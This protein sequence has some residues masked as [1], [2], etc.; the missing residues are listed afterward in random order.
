MVKTIQAFAMWMILLPLVGVSQNSWMPDVGLRV[1]TNRSSINL[2]DVN[3]SN[4]NLEPRTS[5]GLAAVLSWKITERTE[6]SLEPGFLK[7]GSRSAIA[8]TVWPQRQDTALD[9]TLNYF[10]IP[11][12]IRHQRYESRRVNPFIEAGLHLDH[13]RN[14]SIEN[15]QAPLLDEALANANPNKLAFSAG[16]GYKNL[17]VLDQDISLGLRVFRDLTRT[18]FDEERKFIKQR[19]VQLYVRVVF[20]G[21]KIA[22][23]LQKKKTP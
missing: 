4:S 16:F 2:R 6:I 10:N 22:E 8:Q 20:D 3:G 19:N 13:Y 7:L 14:Y 23:K 1:H 15:A 17:V 11:V 18:W 9:I 12:F 5:Q 21:G